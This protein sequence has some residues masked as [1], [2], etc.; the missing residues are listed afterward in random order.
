LTQG[1]VIYCKVLLS[2]GLRLVDGFQ[3][4]KAE[5]MTSKN[6]ISR[7]RGGGSLERCFGV[8]PHARILAITSSKGKG[9]RNSRKFDKGGGGVGGRH[10]MYWTT[11]AGNAVVL[12]GLAAM[13][14]RRHAGGKKGEK[15][16]LM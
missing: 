2:I 9:G 13:P 14:G 5:D 1:V 15:K 6:D 11:E 7:G 4:V 8:F 16:T 3:E 10:V 12:E